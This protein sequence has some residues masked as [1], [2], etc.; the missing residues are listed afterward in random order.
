[1]PAAVSWS[2]SWMCWACAA[3]GGDGDRFGMA[4]APGCEPARKA[5]LAAAAQGGGGLVAGEQDQGAFVAGVVEGCFQG[6]T[7]AGEH[8]VEAVEQTDPVGD[9]VGAVGREPGQ[10]SWAPRRGRSPVADGLSRR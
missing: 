7:D 9:Q 5:G 6:R 10:G 3:E 8:V 1:M 4:H 2:G